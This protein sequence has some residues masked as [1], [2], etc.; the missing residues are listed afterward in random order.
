MPK[1]QFPRISAPIVSTNV[2]VVTP[3]PL[4]H[5]G[6]RISQQSVLFHPQFAQMVSSAHVTSTQEHRSMVVYDDPLLDYN[7]SQQ[8]HVVSWETN[9]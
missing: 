8:T 4:S 1:E 9:V 5:I 7:S 6:P 3:M 2:S